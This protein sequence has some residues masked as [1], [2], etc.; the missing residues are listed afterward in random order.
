MPSVSALLS[1]A[2]VAFT[3]E[4]D[5]EFEHRSPHRTTLMRT[6]QGPWLTSIVMWWNCMKYVGDRPSQRQKELERLARTKI[7][8]LHGMQRWG[9]ITVDSAK[10]IRAT[11]KGPSKPAKFGG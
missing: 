4:L 6:G 5:N 2:L 1:Q 7:N 8:P 11:A 3:I 9:Y 10:Q